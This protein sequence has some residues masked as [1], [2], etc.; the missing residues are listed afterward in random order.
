MVLTDLELVNVC[1]LFSNV[2]SCSLLVVEVPEQLSR[3]SLQGAHPVPKGS[4]T[5]T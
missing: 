3:A 2:S 4:T 1:L 5:V